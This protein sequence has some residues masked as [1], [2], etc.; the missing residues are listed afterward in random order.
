MADINIISAYQPGRVTISSGFFYACWLRTQRKD[1]K[2]G[3]KNF[4]K[5]FYPYLYN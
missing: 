4:L 5:Q 3:I 1:D 2:L